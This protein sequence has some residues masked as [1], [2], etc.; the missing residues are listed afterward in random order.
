MF[1]SKTMHKVGMQFS[2]TELQTTCLGNLLFSWFKDSPDQELS[3]DHDLFMKTIAPK[4]TLTSQATQSLVC[5]AT[6][7]DQG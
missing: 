6:V 1:L 2:Q 7:V 3:A 5:I 4:A